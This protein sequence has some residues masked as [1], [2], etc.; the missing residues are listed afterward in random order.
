MVIE[1]DN[2]G[3]D[4]SVR[5]M[6]RIFANIEA[7]YNALLLALEI[8]AMDKRVAQWRVK[9][10]R[11]F[12]RIWA[13]G[14]Q[15]GLMQNEEDMVDLYLHCLGRVLSIDGVFVPRALLPINLAAEKL[16]EGG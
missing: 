6:R 10:L 3:K 8:N 14:T 15:S 11:I 12:E 5:Q 13:Y 2:W 7:H 9:T 16:A 1:D 4:P